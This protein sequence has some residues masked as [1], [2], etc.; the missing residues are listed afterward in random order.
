LGDR[1]LAAV[2]ALGGGALIC[3]RIGQRVGSTCNRF[4]RTVILFLQEPP[5]TIGALGLLDLYQHILVFSLL[6]RR[7]AWMLRLMGQLGK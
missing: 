5:H 2:L 4:V 3:Q 6:T 7:L 1:I